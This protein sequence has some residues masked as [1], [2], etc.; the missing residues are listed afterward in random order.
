MSK[1][2]RKYRYAVCG[3]GPA[4]I[5]YL[6]A[7]YRARLLPDM[8]AQGLVMVD[9]ESNPGGGALTEYRITANTTAG[10]FLECLEGDHAK[11]F[12]SLKG[13][14]EELISILEQRR[15]E[16]VDLILIGKFLQI[17]GAK[18]IEYIESLGG[19]KLSN[20]C[21]EEIRLGGDGLPHSLKLK[22]VITDNVFFLF[23]NKVLL[24]FGAN[25]S[26]ATVK[27]YICNQFSEAGSVMVSKLLLADELLRMDE[28]SLSKVLSGVSHFLV[29]GSSHSSMS[30]IE[31]VM[32]VKKE[33][34]NFRLSVLYRTPIKVFYSSVE[35]AIDDGYEFSSEKDVCPLS[36]GVN[37]FGGLRFAAKD[38]GLE[39]LKHG[40]VGLRNTP[41][42]LYNSETMSTQGIL[43]LTRNVDKVAP[44][45]GYTPI[46]I[47][48]FDSE[49]K[50][51]DLAKDGFGYKV[52]PYGELFDDKGRKLPDIYSFGIGAGQ[53]ASIEVG[54]E[55]S[56]RKRV[57][58]VWL[59]HFD[60]GK[61]VANALYSSD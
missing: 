14:H 10:T 29:L 41:V 22:N 58:G 54:G 6:F 4:G 52:S 24:N 59:Y 55:L 38:I 30:V 40:S 9:A 16:P 19:T 33:S 18:I 21:L 50:L 3:L 8:V 46:K 36:G 28:R 27:D 47:P 45:L 49:N 42:D 25:Q 34:N 61:K 48:V 44:C 26:R 13:E 35:N 23:A 1:S 12:D 15:Q 5:G 53:R 51:V 37:R 32:T 17:I 20:S 39:I 57:D 2:E 56:F 11:I 7:C 60:I 31:R 43:D